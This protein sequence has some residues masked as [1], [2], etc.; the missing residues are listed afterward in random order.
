[1]TD[2]NV[3][4]CADLSG[5]ILESLDRLEVKDCVETGELLSIAFITVLQALAEQGELI[6]EQDYQTIMSTIQ[7]KTYHS[8]EWLKTPEGRA[9]MTSES[10]LH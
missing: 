2:L 8:I 1:M 3:S 6:G 5:T 10:S 4:V 7:Q 9:T